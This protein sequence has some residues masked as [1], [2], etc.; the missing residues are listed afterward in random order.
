MVGIESYGVALPHFRLSAS[1]Y[2]EA[3]GNCSARGLKQKAFC[4]YDEDPVTLGIEAARQS[5]ERLPFDIEVSA[6]FFGVTTPPYD[7][8]PSA[9]TLPTALFNSRAIRVTEITGS[10]QAGLQAL[11]SAIEFC[12]THKEQY[13]LAVTADAPV[14]KVDSGFEHSLGAAA[15][16]FIV[17]SQGMVAVYKDSISLTRETF[18]SRFRRHG[19]ETLTDLE[20]R[21][22]DNLIVLQDLGDLLSNKKVDKV[23]RLALGIE[24][25]LGRRAGKILGF[26]KA[27]IDALWC[28]IGDAGAASAPLALAAS[29]DKARVGEKILCAGIGAGA[30][31]AWFGAGSQLSKRRRKGSKVADLIVGGELVDYLTYLKHRRVLSSKVRR[32]S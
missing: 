5:L 16:A 22:R 24:T 32:G 4:S 7:E 17:G 31:A 12:S 21:T 30:T 2:V 29:L 25:S 6:L 3:W 23:R 8:K 1:A 9:A 26:P 20:L 15:A 27:E 14:G 18:G 10:P 19:E 13:A 28:M 11:I